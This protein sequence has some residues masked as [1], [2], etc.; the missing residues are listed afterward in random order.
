MF[1]IPQAQTYCEGR[2]WDWDDKITTPPGLY[3][4]P[5]FFLT[6]LP[7]N[8]PISPTQSLTVVKSYLLSVLY[9]KLWRITACTS[10]SLRAN[11]L[12]A[13][14]L[15]GLV[16]CLCRNAIEAR[17]AERQ[18][19]KSWNPPAISWYS[20][21]TGLNIALFPVIFF[22]SGLYYT[23]V[24]S[25]LLV[26]VAYQNHLGRVGLE[27]PGF[28]NDVWTVVL[29]IATLFMRQTN[30]FWVVVYMGGLEVVH[31]VKSLKP[32][33]VPAGGMPKWDWSVMARLNN[34]TQRAS[35][36]DV[37]DPALNISWPDGNTFDSYGFERGVA[38]WIFLD[39]V[40]SL[41]SI[42]IAAICNP[43]KVLRQVWPHITVMG[44]FAGF[45]LWNGGVVLGDKSNHI[46]TIHLTQMLYIWPFFA[47]F[48]APLLIS[49]VLSYISMPYQFITHYIGFRRL[50]TSSQPKPTST[51]KAASSAESDSDSGWGI[52]SIKSRRTSKG[53]S[54]RKGGVKETTTT[55][56]QQSQGGLRAWQ[57]LLGDLT[58]YLIRYKIYY[59]FYVLG[60]VVLS[61]VIVKYNT[62]IH[63]F[64]LADN[65]HYMFY[66]FRYTIL[67]SIKLRYLLVV[68][69]TAARWLVWGRL[70]GCSSNCSTNPHSNEHG[71]VAAKYINTPF[72][73]EELEKALDKKQAKVEG[74]GIDAT[75]TTPPL[76]STVL[77]WL[78]ATSLSLITAPLV[79]PRYFILPW[80]FFRLLV[81]AWPSHGCLYDNLPFFGPVSSYPHQRQQQQGRDQGRLVCRVLDRIQTLG[82]KIDLTLVFETVW[83]VAI[84]LATMYIF[85]SRPFYWRN[86]ETGEL[87]DGGRVQ[88]FMW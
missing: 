48:S 44:L 43:V 80:V 77:L 36:G 11:N 27:R 83:F 79:E 56:P 53:K 72:P 31:V 66:V 82:R 5:P 88:R 23:D 59:P 41:L 65:R 28:L 67:R 87:L 21:H 30:V 54:P 55:Q 32:S 34:Y 26:L 40:F 18:T 52:K 58:S 69:Y 42:G 20:L 33:P 6:F 46:A 78:L 1:H 70:A 15:T 64:T 17:T 81:P 35:V 12:L 61:V 16:A 29:G 47:F 68:G 60:T 38:N 76:T 71:E 19:G 2:F 50:L 9:H 37:H 10:A 13:T 85:L 3:A 51:D 8:T 73:T 7:L 4:L 24:V 57:T 25:T 14:L 86:Q 75:T 49:S 45:V 74:A 63:P 62:I 22:F 39:W 84:N